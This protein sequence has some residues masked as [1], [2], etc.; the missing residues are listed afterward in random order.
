MEPLDTLQTLWPPPPT[1]RGFC[2]TQV[3]DDVERQIGV[4][5]PAD[6]QRFLE[7][8]G[9]GY[10]GLGA[11]D[12]YWLVVRSPLAEQGYGNLVDAFRIHNGLLSERR[13]VAPNSVP[14]PILPESGGLFPFA[15][16][17]CGFE[18]YWLTREGA[19]DWPLVIDNGSGKHVLL[20]FSFVDFVLKLVR[21]EPPHKSFKNTIDYD[22]VWTP[23]DEPR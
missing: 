8:Y 6:F 9:S 7:V 23:I 10:I 13:V 5:P 12:P 20:E 16:D 14:Y 2:S 1:C 17:S 21:R 11:V 3:W 19:T 22:L 4:R 18:Y 15:H